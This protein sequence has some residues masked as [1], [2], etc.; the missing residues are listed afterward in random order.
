[1]FI[2]F[3][4]N[5]QLPANCLKNQLNQ[6]SMYQEWR[7]NEFQQTGKDYA[8]QDEVDVYDPTHDDFRD[9]A[10]EL[11]ETVNWLNPKPNSKILDIGCGTGNFSIQLS[12]L[13]EKV[14]A[15]DVSETML[16]F[17]QSKAIAANATN[18]SFSHT[19]YL[20]FDLPKDHLDGVIS[21]LSLHHLPDFW[22]SVALNRIF[23]VLKPGGRFY[24]YDV[25]IPDQQSKDTIDAFIDRQERRGGAF[26]KEDTI[27]HFKE[28]F[29]TFDWV[30][31]KL[32]LDAGFLIEKEILS[33]GVFKNYFC[34]K[35]L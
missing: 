30:M 35:P 26:M 17:A 25:V 18:I 34:Q 5:C 10:K 19:G 6:K 11:K 27:I 32:L 31:K 7:Y 29:S 22:K 3:P 4:I 20:N 8:S 14:Y 15:I 28:E 1:M 12:T 16:K 9:L 13:C 24:L 33:D 21:S 2:I 23:R